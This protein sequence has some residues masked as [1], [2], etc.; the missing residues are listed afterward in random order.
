MCKRFLRVGFCVFLALCFC[1]TAT[2]HSG[3]TDSKGGHNDNINGGYHY[4]H[5]YPAHQ[6]INGEC[7]YET[8]NIQSEDT[9]SS[10]GGYNQW[11]ESIK[12]ESATDNHINGEYQYETE[13]IQSEEIKF[14][15]TTQEKGDLIDYLIGIIFIFPFALILQ[16]I[17][18]LILLRKYFSLIDVFDNSFLIKTSVSSIIICIQ[19]AIILD[20]F[21]SNPLSWFTLLIPVAVFQAIIIIPLIKRIKYYKSFAGFTLTQ[22]F[23]KVNNTNLCLEFDENLLPIGQDDS[24]GVYGEYTCYVS[25][26]GKRRHYKYNCCNATSEKNLFSSLSYSDCSKCKKHKP[27]LLI[28]EEQYIDFSN[29]VKDLKLINIHIKEY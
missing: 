11:V 29:V 9:E 25:A 5:G 19:L 6:H 7:P 3:R 26:S 20:Y 28:S 23:N 15:S 4:H 14:G 27:E 12:D 1:I 13:S 21:S 17:I 16:V 10:S 18:L 2:A 22:I 8:E 24:L